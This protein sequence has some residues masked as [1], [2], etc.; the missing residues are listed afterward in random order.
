MGNTANRIAT[1]RQRI[2]MQALERWRQRSTARTESMQRVRELGPGA[3]DPPERRARYDARESNRS[4]AM[5]GQERMIGTWDPT[6]SAPSETAQRIA[7]PVA[8]LTPLPAQ[9]GIIPEGLATGLLISPTLLLTNHHVFP[10]DLDAARYAANFLH[11][12]QEQGIHDGSYFELLPNDFYFS[13]E[14]LDICVVAVST[15]STQGQ[16][17]AEYG[18]VRLIETAG[19]ILR[20]DPMNIIQHPYGGARQYGTS[21]NR[22]LD[23][24]DN[25]FLHYETDTAEGSSGSPVFNTNWE[26]VG[27]HHC[28]IPKTDPD[29]NV[30]NTDG[31]VWHPDD[32]DTRRIAWIANEGTRVSSIVSRLKAIDA[33]GRQGE[34]LAELLSTT[35]DPLAPRASAPSHIVSTPVPSPSPGEPT[36]SQTVFNLSG[37]TTINFITQYAPATAAPPNAPAPTPPI[38]KDAPPQAE[39]KAL[40]FDPD[41][42]ARPGY[43]PRF[44]GVEIPPPA[45]RPERLSELYTVGDYRQHARTTR[46]VPILALDGRTDSD[47][48]KLPYRH[49]SLVMNKTYRML[50]W[51]ASNADYRDETRG[52]KRPR[53]AF[54]GEDWRY[55]KR[56]PNRYQLGND[57]IYGPA[58]NFDRGHIVRRE[59]SCWGTPGQDTEYANADTYHWT[60]C[61]PQHELFNQE[62]PKGEEYRG[63]KGVWGYFENQLADRIKAGGGQA[64]IFA[65][66]V[67][68]ASC[69]QKDFGTGPV[70]YPTQFWKVVIVPQ[71]ESTQ[72]GLLAY[73]FLFDQTDVIDEFGLDT[74]EALRELS[75]TFKRQKIKLD[76]LCARAGIVLDPR[77]MQADQH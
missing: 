27:L 19:K 74:R 60:N 10:R 72:P 73:G 75:D 67:L 21:N 44:L 47:P 51:A 66:P 1:A 48:L 76:E 33:Q 43:D 65:G 18:F 23:I 59:D 22:L 3:G 69:R 50:H 16:A 42:T 9:P 40:L 29:G 39:E 68:D 24:L 53:T 31:S 12:K 54:G 52:D 34:L 28:G 5:L 13:D 35:A 45:V 70:Y 56:V 36:M 14:S 77:I 58:G 26:L 2:A 71:D 61:T 4:R 30:L 17:L 8:R 38:P 57:D 11:E 49:F 7:R 63:R 15:R 6:F 41:Y 55:D 32:D 37:P 46:N 64:V 62:S 20:G 25:G